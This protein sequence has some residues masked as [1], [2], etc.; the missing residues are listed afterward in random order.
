MSEK[1]EMCLHSWPLRSQPISRIAFT[2]CSLTSLPGLMPAL[3]ASTPRLADIFNSASA[4]GLRLEF[5]TQTNRTFMWHR[6]KIFRGAAF[7]KYDLGSPLTQEFHRCHTQRP[8]DDWIAHSFNE[9]WLLLYR[10]LEKLRMLLA[11]VVKETRRIIPTHSARIGRAKSK[12]T[13]N[14]PEPPATAAERI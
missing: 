12:S 13:S 4:I 3:Q 8:H 5:L 7:G 10:L 14:G 11:C 9:P 2:A 6:L 1:F